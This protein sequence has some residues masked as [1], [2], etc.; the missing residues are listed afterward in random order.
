MQVNATRIYERIEKLATFTT[1]SHGVTR[2]PFTHESQEVNALVAEWMKE[3]GMEV[4]IDP[5]NNVIGRYE[6]KEPNKPVLLIGSHLDTVVEAGKYDGILGVISGIEVIHT[7]HESRIMPNYPIEVVAFC[8]EEGARFHTTLIGSR[9]I[10]GTLRQED[11]LAVDKDGISIRAALESIG[12][13]PD[14][15]HEAARDAESLLGYV[16]LHIEQGPVLEK[17]GQSCGVVSGIA[18]A[19]RMKFTVKGEAGHAGTVPMDLRKDALMATSDM[20]LALEKIAQSYPDLVA[21][22]GTLTVLPGASNVIPGLVEGSID[23][24]CMDDR[25]RKRVMTQMRA[26]WQAIAT[27]RQV[28]LQLEKVLESPATLCSKKFIDTISGVLI[29]QDMNP[30][31]LISGAGHDAMAVAAI[32]D[33]GMIF[34]RCKGGISH[35]PAEEATVQD[36]EEGATVLL[37]TVLKLTK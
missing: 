37:N 19:T 27:R 18:G 26:E 36:M 31:Q 13:N 21:T 4:R 7:L 12:Q 30:V 23:I 16:E 34:V 2:L 25:E 1:T 20:L 15:Y 3:A 29:E 28:T 11:L 14:M 33:V 22:A 35:N 8:D 5:L 6:G 9:A 32:T 24:R 17:I 10:A